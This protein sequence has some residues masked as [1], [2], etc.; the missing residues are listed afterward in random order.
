MW[1]EDWPDEAPIQTPAPI[2]VPAAARRQDRI[3]ERIELPKTEA[4]PQQ[5]S[6]DAEIRP[7]VKRRTGDE[8]LRIGQRWKRRLPRVCW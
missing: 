5:A 6:E 4:P 1:P 3:Q 7:R 8:D 2:T